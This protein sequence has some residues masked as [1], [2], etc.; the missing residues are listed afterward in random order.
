MTE[1][2]AVLMMAR[3]TRFSSAIAV[4]TSSIGAMTLHIAHVADVSPQARAT[5]VKSIPSSRSIISLASI[6]AR[7]AARS[8]QMP[9][10]KRLLLSPEEYPIAAVGFSAST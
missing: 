6:S 2:F 3:C 5:A 4:R 7:M 1:S 8:D 10:E 9:K